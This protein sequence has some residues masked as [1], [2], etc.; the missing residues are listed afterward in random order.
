[1]ATHHSPAC[2]PDVKQPV[3]TG[4]TLMSRV[5]GSGF[6]LC[7]HSNV[8]SGTPLTSHSRRIFC[9]VRAITFDSGMTKTGAFSDA[10]SG[11]TV[12]TLHINGDGSFV[13]QAA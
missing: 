4:H 12:L 2:I 11:K 8:G 10:T 7:D 1:M 5:S 6:P 9:P 13:K 3:F